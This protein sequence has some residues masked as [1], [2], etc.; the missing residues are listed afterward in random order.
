MLLIIEALLLI[1]A[2][3]GQDHRVA[4]AVEGQIFPLD[5][6][7]N[8]VDDVY[9]GCADKMANLVES[10][11][12]EK[13]INNSPDFKNAWQEG[14][15]NATEQDD[16]LTKNNSIAIYVYTNNNSNVYSNFNMAVRNGKQNYKEQTFKWYSLQFLLTDAVKKL[17]RTQNKCKTTYR[18][19]TVEFYKNVT[20]ENVRFGSFTSSS[21]ERK[22]AQDF[23]KQSC[24][25]IKTCEGADVIKYSKYPEQKEV[26]IPPY[27]MFKVTD[28]KT[29]KDQKN[30]WCETVYQLESIGK[31]SDL[32]C[33]VAFK[34]PTKFHKNPPRFN[35]YAFCRCFSLNLGGIISHGYYE[36]YQLEAFIGIVK[37]CGCLEEHQLGVHQLSPTDGETYIKHQWPRRHRLIS[38]NGEI[39]KG[40]HQPRRHRQ[41]ISQRR[42]CYQ[43]L[44]SVGTDH[45]TLELLRPCYRV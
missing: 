11:Y 37:L 45:I 1:L 43:F 6:A 18:G 44:H 42:S 10:N 32:N 16:T 31:K 8:S 38:S 5:M 24:F 34:K 2:S 28:V 33:T 26:L 36:I 7:P 29:K 35:I 19:T 30:L 13:E 4:A 3:L 39:Y 12:L 14:E 23:G 22:V 41:K 21:L 40:H 15:V 9:D 20:G 17:T 27:E 25:K